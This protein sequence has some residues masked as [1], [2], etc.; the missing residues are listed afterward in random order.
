[1]KKFITFVNGSNSGIQTYD[2]AV[3]WAQKQ[4]VNGRMDEVHV[5]E[6][7]EVIER[8]VPSIRTVPFRASEPNEVAK[9]A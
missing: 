8:T 2:K 4:M 3:E 5:A 9:A 1:M 6:V 7:I